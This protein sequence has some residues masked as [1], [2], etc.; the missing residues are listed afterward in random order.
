MELERIATNTYD[1]ETMRSTG[2][3]YVDKTGLLHPIADCS[4]GNQ[5]FLARPRRFGK[6]LLVS[7]L[8]SEAGRLG[9]SL[10][11]GEPL[12]AQ[13]MFLIEDVAA[14]GPGGQC[15]LLVDEYDKPLARWVG[16]E[17][18]L[19]FQRF[20]KSF[21]SVVKKTES[22][23]RFCLMTG[24]SRFSKMSIFSNLNN[25]KDLT[26]SPFATTLLGYTHG[27]VRANFPG[28]LAA[29]AGELGT[30]ADGAFARLERMYPSRGGD[31]LA[32]WRCGQDCDF[33]DRIV[34]NLGSMR[35]KIG[36]LPGIFLSMACFGG[37][38]RSRKPLFCPARLPEG[39]N[40][41]RK[42]PF[43]P[44]AL[45]RQ[46]ACRRL[47]RAQ[48]C[49][50][51]LEAQRGAVAVAGRI[52]GPQLGVLVEDG[53][54][55]RGGVVGNEVGLDANPGAVLA[56]G[57]DG[58]AGVGKNLP[59]DFLHLAGLDVQLAVHLRDGAEGANLR[60]AVG[61]DGRQIVC[62]VLFEIGQYLVHDRAPIAKKGR[63]GRR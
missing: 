42:S 51:V 34:P 45:L 24:V 9:V 43:C 47:K 21:Y 48:R 31:S 32:G 20:L 44:A 7:T 4:M 39:A 49:V 13:L 5:F 57:A 2:I 1:F 56:H 25:L 54:A 10:R 58:G 46:H 50:D 52:H 18:A 37:K 30:D 63:E 38:R 40:R 14:E 26:M 61:V 8:R 35:K 3:T 11:A 55:Q 29:L 15:V 28:R 36:N 62:G 6:S 60:V 23:Q 22:L 59:V 53:V 41:S 12:A 17:E 16:S 19:P 27:E 33:L